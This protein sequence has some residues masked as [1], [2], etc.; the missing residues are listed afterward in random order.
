MDCDE[1]D[2]SRLVLYVCSN[3]GLRQLRVD[4]ILTP[5]MFW[6]LEACT[7]LHALRLD[8]LDCEDNLDD[9]DVAQLIENMQ[10]LRYLHFIGPGLPD[11]G[12]LK[13]FENCKQ[14]QKLYMYDFQDSNADDPDDSYSEVAV[15]ASPPLTV[16][17]VHTISTLTL[18]AVLYTYPKLT[19]LGIGLSTVESF[20]SALQVLHDYHITELHL[21]APRGCTFANIHLLQNL[22]ALYLYD[23]AGLT[24]EH[25]LAIARNNPQLNSLRIYSAGLVASETV[26]ELVKPLC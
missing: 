18:A 23:C 9:V 13:L 8:V 26:I 7:E 12:L 15:N 24:N 20:D 2:R 17:Y 6:I 5:N 14:L 10:N 19:N 25:L 16:L 3:V 21:G 1:S 22:A 11:A 4:R